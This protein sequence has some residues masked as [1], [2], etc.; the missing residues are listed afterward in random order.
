MSA[1]TAL[2]AALSASSALAALVGTRIWPDVIPED[3][4][5]P[6]VVFARTATQPFIA[7]DGAKLAEVADLTIGC[8]AKTRGEADAVAD[9]ATAAVIAGGLQYAGRD[10]G[11]DPETGLFAATLTV[12]HFS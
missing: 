8:W 4:A 6:A 7:L 11:F 2:Y 3:R 5:M 9:A 12:K 1:E 10:A